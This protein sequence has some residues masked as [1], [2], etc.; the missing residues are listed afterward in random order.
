MKS[1]SEKIRFTSH[2]S[3]MCFIALSVIALMV[4]PP[5][6]QALDLELGDILKQLDYKIGGR[7][8]FGL[9]Y[10]DHDTGNIPTDAAHTTL[11]NTPDTTYGDIQ[12]KHVSS[13]A[14]I[15]A[16]STNDRGITMGGTVEYAFYDGDFEEFYAFLEGAFGRMEF[17]RAHA[18]V[19]N[20]HVSIPIFVPYDSVDFANA[21]NNARQ[22]A[23]ISTFII[24]GSDNYKFSFYTPRLFGLK[25]GFSFLPTNSNATADNS[26][27]IA[28]K[29]DT[30]DRLYFLSANYERNLEKDVGV[31]IDLAVSL[32]YGIGNAPK[33]LTTTAG[34]PIKHRDPQFMSAGFSA[35]WE[36]ITLGS[37]F[38]Y[39]DS[40]GQKDRVFTVGLS[41]E[42]GPF[43][44]GSA[45]R[46][47][48][49]DPAN[50]SESSANWAASV[51]GTYFFTDS[52][53]MGLD[54]QYVVDKN[55]NPAAGQDIAYE[56][57]ALSVGLI[58]SFSF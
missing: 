35:E 7:S 15:T 55:R 20:M 21:Y 54:V 3:I 18:V 40:L 2:R 8:A 6:A 5:R 30:I 34:Q 1:V 4:Q 43:L 49:R 14:Y 13:K 33:G 23:D 44:M 12:L 39:R 17:G 50:S 28:P 41:Y 48:V 27:Q 29:N 37:G 52:F 26:T 47:S 11:A 19:E 56:L 10:L 42:L 57:E 38:K 9:Y 31:D 45:Y 32:G 53:R 58:A 16:S 25:M 36:R 46:Y 51:G 24:V 22:S